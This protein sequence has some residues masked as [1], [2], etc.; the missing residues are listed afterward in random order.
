MVHKVPGHNSLLCNLKKDR[1]DIEV[2]VKK[3]CIDAI[4]GWSR[5]KMED[6]EVQPNMHVH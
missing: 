6:I 2:D 4:Q 5:L 1:K 3:I